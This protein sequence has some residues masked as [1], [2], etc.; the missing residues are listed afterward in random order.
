MISLSSK[1][2]VYN[3]IDKN[4]LNMEKLVDDLWQ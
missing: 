4:Y 1:L 2:K 3:L